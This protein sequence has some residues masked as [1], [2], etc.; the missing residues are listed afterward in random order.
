MSADTWSGNGEAT[1]IARPVHS[2]SQ[3]LALID[4]RALE[5]AG[6]RND[7]VVAGAD[8]MA[9]NLA[10]GAVAGDTRNS[11]IGPVTEAAV[12]VQDVGP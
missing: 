3:R 9:G 4:E 1:E 6:G 2:R 8:D 12:G 7:V 5:T 11:Q 10:C